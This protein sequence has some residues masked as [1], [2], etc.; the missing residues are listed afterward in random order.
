LA[1]S[2]SNASETISSSTKLNL[3]A[4]IG[5][6]VSSEL[7]LLLRFGTANT[8]AAVLDEACQQHSYSGLNAGAVEVFSPC[9]HSPVS[10]AEAK[11]RRQIDG[12]DLLRRCREPGCLAQVAQ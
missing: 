12:I 3:F 9:R 10:I 5:V 6:Q 1:V 8:N 4:S 2:K 7:N 11:G